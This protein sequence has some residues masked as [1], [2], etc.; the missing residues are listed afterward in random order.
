MLEI[1][2]NVSSL[3]LSKKEKI[4]QIKKLI[5]IPQKDVYNPIKISGAFNDNYIEYKSNSEKDK[6]ISIKKYLDN[7]RSYLRR[8]INHK[9][10]SGE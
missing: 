8:M 7:I 10:K 2:K 4:E 6:S 1:K 9:K 5:S 3:L